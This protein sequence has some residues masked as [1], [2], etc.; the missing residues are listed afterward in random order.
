MKRLFLA[1]YMLF[2]I[3][4]AHQGTSFSGV[5]YK[6]VDENGVAHFTDSLNDKSVIE[7]HDVE[8]ITIKDNAESIVPISKQTEPK[9]KKEK[10]SEQPIKGKETLKDKP[11]KYYKKQTEFGKQKDRLGKHYENKTKGGHEKTYEKKKREGKKK[12]SKNIV[13]AIPAQSE[14]NIL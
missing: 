4:C 9:P 5:I 2:L 10:G 8:I 7:K 6:W 11:S 14:K 12:I 3:L 13:K 1:S